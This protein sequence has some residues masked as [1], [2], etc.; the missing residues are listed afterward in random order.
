M[1]LSKLDKNIY[2]VIKYFR[3]THRIKMDNFD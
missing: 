2:S 1:L 3:V